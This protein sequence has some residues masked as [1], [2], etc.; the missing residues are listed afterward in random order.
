MANKLL[1]ISVVAVC[2]TL[3]ALI[4]PAE[5]FTQDLA[6]QALAAFPS[7]TRQISY[8]NLA[9][10]RSLPDYRQIRSALL[11]RQMLQFE[12]FLR[13]IGADPE[14]DVNEAV[15][16]LRGDLGKTLFGLAS[17]Q[18]NSAAAQDFI[19]REKLPTR[20]YD[21]FTL[22]AYGPG[23]LPGD[24]FFTFINP[25]M[26]AFGTMN[27]L[28]ALLDG[29]LG[30]RATLSSNQ[31]FVGWVGKLDGAAPDWGITTGKAALNL[32]APWLSGGS[33]PLA[34]LSS[35]LGPMKA[36]LYQ[37]GWDGGFNAQITAICQNAQSA[38]TLATLL[39]LWRDSA[40]LMAP[41]SAGPAAFI[42]SLKI[43]A[44]GDRVEI[45]G[46]GPPGVFVQFLK[47]ASQR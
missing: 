6:Q 47:N 3:A 45:S 23:L 30:Q 13:S 20:E 14:T 8:V 24:L 37:A 27:D 5:A 2:L 42:Q 1:T 28:E 34:K 38:Q 15:V 31:S 43:G 26:A 41:H 33:K 19:A 40:P 29:Y 46:F 10:L 21:G 39:S 11:N 22:D 25:G 44:S 12:E 18:F 32:A 35:V 17:G 9:Q 16:G 36:V 7:D 4:N